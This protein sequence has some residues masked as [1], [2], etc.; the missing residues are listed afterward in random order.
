MLL[1]QLLNNLSICLEG[2]LNCICTHVGIKV[3]VFI[4]K[5]TYHIHNYVHKCMENCLFQQSHFPISFEKL[6]NN[7]LPKISFLCKLCRPKETQ[8]KSDVSLQPSHYTIYSLMVFPFEKHLAD[9][10][11]TCGLIF[12][13]NIPKY[14][15]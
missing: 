8:P 14:K 3:N 7:K 12:Y 13:K 9:N 15:Q 2:F 1:K 5:N 10:L 4:Q 6:N 11:K